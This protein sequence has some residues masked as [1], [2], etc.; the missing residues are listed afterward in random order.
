MDIY[1][2]IGLEKTGTT[3]IQQFLAANR[4]ALR[5]DGIL[6]PLSPGEQNQTRLAAFALDPD[7]SDSVLRRHE[8][9]AAD[10]DFRASFRAAFVAEAQASGCRQMVLSNEHCS[11]RLRTVE[12]IARLKALLDAVGRV[13]R[14]VVYL[15]RQ[16]DFL[17]STYST[18]IKTGAVTRFA[19]PRQ[20]KV[21]RRYDFAELLAGWAAVF[22]EA[23]IQ[24]RLF[25]REELAGDDLLTDFCVAMD[26]ATP[27]LAAGGRRRNVSLSAEGVEYLRLLNAAVARDRRNGRDQRVLVNRVQRATPGPGISLSAASRRAFLA[28]VAESNDAVRRRF[29]PDRPY[30][31]APVDPATRETLPPTLTVERV[32]AITAAILRD[33]MGDDDE[34]IA[35]HE[36]RQGQRRAL[37]IEARETRRTAR[38]QR[39]A[40]RRADLPGNA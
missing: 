32:M 35:E 14:V 36:Q 10:G 4:A 25:A 12:E 6:F 31:F 1:L 16:D 18:S 15:R 28:T 3:T 39:R 37:M 17:I 23:V 29:F 20:R 19:L 5:A 22:G 7:S 2:H 38:E 13:K 27:G 30:L 21:E 24:P 8:D 9:D 26:I 11:S 33:E 40:R 34:T